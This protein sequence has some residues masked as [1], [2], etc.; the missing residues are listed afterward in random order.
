MG[1]VRGNSSNTVHYPG[2]LTVAAGSLRATEPAIHTHT[3]THMQLRAL[4][5]WQDEFLVMASDGLFDVMEDQS[6]IDTVGNHLKEHNRY[7]RASSKAVP[8][9]LSLTAVEAFSTLHE[10]V[11]ML[12]C[13][14]VPASDVSVS[15]SFELGSG[16]VSGSS[17][18]LMD[19]MTA[20]A[21]MHLRALSTRSYR[22]AADKLTALALEKG[23]MDNVTVVIIQF[24]WNNHDGD[25]GSGSVQH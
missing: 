19:H 15:G 21:Q 6:V 13:D 3:H 22:G 9:P 25:A 2:G 1:E 16:D 12:P 8:Q 4:V 5:L 17:Q 18:R 11:A 7:T 24:L 10:H 23:S 14:V 20:C